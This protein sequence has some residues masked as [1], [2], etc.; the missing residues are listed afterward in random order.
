M[1][2]TITLAGKGG[3]GKTTVAALAIKYLMETQP[4]FSSTWIHLM[5][6]HCLML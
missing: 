2:T 1:T 5:V 6:R 4:G 3:V